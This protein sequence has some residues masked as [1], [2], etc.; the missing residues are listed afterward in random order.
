MERRVPRI[1]H[2]TCSVPKLYG[3]QSKTYS[4]LGLYFLM[5][6]PQASLRSADREIVGVL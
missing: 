2:T 6:S 1:G 3:W 5:C 4:A